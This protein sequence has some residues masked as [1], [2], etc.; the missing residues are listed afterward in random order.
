MTFHHT[1]NDLS[2]KCLRKLG[3]RRN[4]RHSDVVPAVRPTLCANQPL[5]LIF[6]A[7][8]CPG[9]K[10]CH[11]RKGFKISQ[12]PVPSS[13]QIQY[14]PQTISVRFEKRPRNVSLLGQYW[15]LLHLR[16]SCRF[17]SESEQHEGLGLDLVGP[18]CVSS[19][20]SPDVTD[21]RESRPALS[22]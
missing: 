22:S 8:K 21:D 15:H 12:S 18:S 11:G 9:L 16:L 4:P 19:V 17:A 1:A 3:W 13:Y 2:A 14:S 10:S 20:S 5:N 7:N 6:Q